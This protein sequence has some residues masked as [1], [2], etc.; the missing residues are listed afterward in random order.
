M[1]KPY[2]LMTEREMMA[3]VDPLPTP[4]RLEESIN[5]LLYDK[6]RVI[7]LMLV[8]VSIQRFAP[9]CWRQLFS[10]RFLH[11]VYQQYTDHPAKVLEGTEEA[12]AKKM[13]A[14]MKKALNDNN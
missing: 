7:E 10:I 11:W 5:S 1:A 6:V 4:V 12:R 8:C 13:L 9:T 3:V 14:V 2:V